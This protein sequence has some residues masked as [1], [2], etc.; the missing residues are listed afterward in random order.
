MLN[1]M[2]MDT[3]EGN[4]RGSA[5]T[6]KSR[7]FPSASQQQPQQPN[8][9]PGM[10][11]PP[12]I[13]P[14][15]Q[16]LFLQNQARAAAGNTGASPAPGFPPQSP[17]RGGA[18]MSVQEL[19]AKLAAS[20][21][22]QQ[23][24][25]PG[26]IPPQLAA[27][28][29]TL[30][31]EHQRAL[32]MQ[33]QQQMM[34]QMQMQQQ[35]R[36]T[37]PASPSGPQAQQ[38]GANAGKMLL[39]MLQNSAA[40][41]QPP[42]SSQQP[43]PQAQPQQQQM[44]KPVP[45]PDAFEQSR[46]NQREQR[47]YTN[48][49]DRDGRNHRDDR[50]DRRNTPDRDDRRRDGRD[51]RDRDRNRDN[52]RV[53]WTLPSDMMSADEIDS[54]IRIQEQ[55]LSS[56][57]NP[58]LEDYYYQNFQIASNPSKYPLHR[59]IT[60]AI[61]P[62]ARSQRRRPNSVPSSPS[63]TST[64]T[65]N[66]SGSGSSDGKSSEGNNA[67]VDPFQNVL[68]R[69][70]SHS[71]RAP[72]PL[73]I[74]ETPSEDKA[75]ATTAGVGAMSAHAQGLTL[76]PSIT[77]PEMDAASV[78]EQEASSALAAASRRVLLL[79][80]SAFGTLLECEDLQLLIQHIG[81]VVHQANSA[82]QAASQAAA[83]ANASNPP[84]LAA[85]QAAQ[86]AQATAQAAQQQVAQL[87]AN[88]NIPSLHQKR[89]R[90]IHKLLA[91]LGLVTAATALQMPITTAAEPYLR[92]EETFVA[93]TLVPK[94]TRLLARALP[95]V[96][97]LYSQPAQS[98]ANTPASTAPIAEMHAVVK[99]FLRNLYVFSTSCAS[100]TQQQQMLVI[101]DVVR[102]VIARADADVF[103]FLVNHFCYPAIL[104]NVVIHHGSQQQQQRYVPAAPVDVLSL[105]KTQAG[106]IILTALMRRLYELCQVPA[107]LSNPTRITLW[108]N[109]HNVVFGG[110]S[111]HLTR[112]LSHAP[113]AASAAPL[114]H[115]ELP[116]PTTADAPAIG[117][118][119]AYL[120]LLRKPANLA[121][122]VGASVE[123]HPRYVLVEAHQLWDLFIYLAANAAPHQK[124]SLHSE[125]APM[126]QL[127]TDAS[128]VPQLQTLGKA[129]NMPLLTA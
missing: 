19:E 127:V 40:R 21:S 27:V 31:P 41:Q 16:M 38:S 43:Q 84:S 128:L 26:G 60:E 94:G 18:G 116:L 62:G 83:Q 2:V 96:Y 114:E 61:V 63:T 66:D 12:G 33:H 53:R 72:R 70:P 11:P 118:L 34:Y 104:P 1:Q 120:G 35:Q 5:P 52:R 106:V 25:V 117:S 110:L 8:I 125:L 50:R 15:L 77:A 68:G 73:L 3:T 36:A 98:S 124:Q 82:I 80:E 81:Q 108:K 37:A 78:L 121:L 91:Q 48:R 75:E 30:P 122:A 95:L 55:Q 93:M 29:Q 129:L 100:E 59:P 102:N 99:V 45:E 123:R 57:M 115:E 90:H 88:F 92:W 9:P 111:G 13:P 101:T 112:L 64:S 58:F 126:A 51:N 71:V 46:Q 23:P 105:A 113:A 24:Q 44:T 87:Q 85:I 20:G 22:Q 74:L 89:Q 54:I 4:T 17:M 107:N 56:D 42:Q 103:S 97:T 14:A 6:G 79:I 109:F 65:S 119:L 32:L 28:L 69:I 10:Q 47:G 49:N 86:S 7:F 67:P 39:Q 76:E